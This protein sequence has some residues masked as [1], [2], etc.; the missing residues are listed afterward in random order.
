[1]NLRIQKIIIIFT[2]MIL[3]M[4]FV[5]YGQT[6]PGFL[7]ISDVL[8]NAQKYFN[9]QVKFQGTVTSVT[10]A[11]NAQT[12][13]FYFLIDNSDRSIKIVANELPAPNQK[14]IVTGI[15]QLDTGTQTPFLREI[16]KSISGGVNNTVQ[17]QQTAQQKDKPNI[18]MFALIGLIALVV[19][20]LIIVMF[21]KPKT[22]I[23]QNI[24]QSVKE[25]EEQKTTQVSYDDINKQVGGMK[26]KQVPTLLAELV[27]L[28]GSK[29]GKKFTLGYENLIG[30]VSGDITLEDTSVSRKQAKIVF[31]NN[32][33]VL[34]NLSETNPTIINGK[35]VNG[36][37]EL[38]KD[39][40]IIMGVIK[41][42][43][44]LI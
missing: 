31:L 41:L 1:M 38:N 7:F 2:I 34:E 33:Y 30:K 13:G 25:P 24:K 15:V 18:L 40:E 4:G 17:Q 5:N 22:T 37:K 26:T 6:Q 39:D 16:S 19:I 11:A 29:S 12:R 8:D 10:N 3:A 14:V 23:P 27:V 44:N 35:K 32:A 28:S 21:K 9:L 42:K 20:A 36:S 43:F